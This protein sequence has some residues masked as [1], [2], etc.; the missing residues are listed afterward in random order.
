MIRALLS[1]WRKEGLFLLGFYLLLSG[2][3]R[4]VSAPFLHL[5]SYKVPLAP[6]NP[7]GPVACLGEAYSVPVLL[8]HLAG[9]S[10]QLPARHTD[11]DL[12]RW[13]QT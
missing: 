12:S 10:G 3:K 11:S 6:K 9:I 5:L 8:G 2:R 7:E 4:R 1:F 13:L